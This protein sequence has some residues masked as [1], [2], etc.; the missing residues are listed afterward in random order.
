M[1][2]EKEKVSATSKPYFPVLIYAAVSVVWILF[3]DWVLALVVPKREA[4]IMAQTYKGWLF[5]LVTSML[6]YLMIRKMVTALMTEVESN[7]N[8]KQKLEAVLRGI[9]EGVFVTDEKRRILMVNKAMEKISGFTENELLGTVYNE[10]LK[11]VSEKTGKE[12]LRIPKTIHE[13]G[14]SARPEEPGLLIRKDGK[15]IAVD[16]IGAPYKDSKGQVIGGVGVIRDVTNE[17]N[18]DRVR[19]D[20]ISLA[21]HQLRSPLTGI[22]WLV[23]LLQTSHGMKD[24]EVTE[25]I[26]KI[27][28]SNQR[29]IELVN[30]LLGVSR[31]ESGALEERMRKRS[32]KLKTVLSGALVEVDL[33]A[34]EKRTIIEG[35]KEVDER[36]E[37]R[38][39]ETQMVQVF[40]NIL[41][42]AVRYSPEGS[43]VII[44]V[45]RKRSRVVVL[46]ED[47]GMGIPKRQM[48]R[49]FEKFFRGDNVAK[50]TVGSGLG[51]Y[52][53]KRLLE[54]HGGKIRIESK[55]GKGTKVYVE[56]PIMYNEK[57]G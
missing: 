31:I 39:D 28:E 10:R 30:D 18:L 48:K 7:Y 27:G 11:F 50:G 21:S 54:A 56:L 22:K 12:L 5:V 51:L 32:M 38:G 40:A 45:K 9:G 1:V 13:R 46:V 25:Y 20:F 26:K 42:N 47:N 36:I 17:R 19:S 43:R 53:V 2:K 44:G 55:E 16:G 57:H 23:E 34:K 49:L 15:K 29:L 8:Q 14:D 6:L 3:S 52:V 33:L 37:L 35:I 24:D 4:Y 41:N